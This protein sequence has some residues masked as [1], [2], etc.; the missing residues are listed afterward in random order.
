MPDPGLLAL[1]ATP[2]AAGLALTVLLRRSLAASTPVRGLAV[3]PLVVVTSFAAT[4]LQGDGV[5]PRVV[6]DAVV[7]RAV[8]AVILVAAAVFVAVNLRQASRLVR[9]GVW[10][11]AAG[12][13]SNATATL[14]FG[15]MPLLDAAVRAEGAYV[16]PGEHPDPQYVVVDGSHPLALLIGDVLPIPALDTV[17]SL[18]DVLLIPGCAILVAH[19]MSVLL[20]PAHAKHRNGAG[21]ASAATA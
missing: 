2:L 19:F 12:A 13:A 14:V 1:L 18:G 5:A 4:R 3:A 11:T 15:S 9:Y 21:G 7:N 20:T 17:L 6:P 16:F 8:A 10:C